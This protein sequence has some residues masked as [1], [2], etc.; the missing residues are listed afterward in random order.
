MLFQFG[1]N[2]TL[3]DKEGKP[4]DLRGFL[5]RYVILYFF[6][7]AGTPGCT[8]EARDF[9]SLLPRFRAAEAEVVGISPDSPQAL[10]KFAQKERLEFVLL[11]DAEG[12]L[13]QGYGVSLNG[14]VQRATFLLDRAGIVRWAWHKVRVPGHAGEVLRTLQALYH[15]DLAVNPWIA[16]RR[17]KRALKLDPVPKELI[18]RVI[19][20]AHLAPSCFNNQPWRFVVAQGEKLEAVKKA[21]PGGNYWALK[22]PAMVAVASRVDLDCRLSDN[23]DYFLF[24]CGMAV[25]FLMVQATQMGLV[26]HPIAGYDPLPVKEILGIPKDYVL[27]TL[28]VLGWPG[29]PAGLGEKHR[30]LELGPR[31]RKPLSAVCG[32]NEMPKEEK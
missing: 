8:Q 29:D 1:L 16:V 3:P 26:A 25:G 21:L 20:A 9:Q 2:F 7:K 13:S 23:R 6:P 30:E 14:K 15:A 5:G 32:W 12:K 31:V 19:E 4:L 11:S 17:A 28:V 22:S 10:S 18:E 27:I 24:D